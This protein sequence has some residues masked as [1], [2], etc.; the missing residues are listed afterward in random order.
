VANSSAL[1]CIQGKDFARLT[2]GSADENTAVKTTCTIAPNQLAA[3]SGL[4]AGIAARLLRAEAEWL[5]TSN[6]RILR[7]ALLEVLQL[8]EAAEAPPP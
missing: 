6:T 7:R 1:E 3:A 8:L 4:P 5:E 2:T